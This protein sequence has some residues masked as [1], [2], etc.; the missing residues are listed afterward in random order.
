MVIPGTLIQSKLLPRFIRVFIAATLPV[1]NCIEFDVLHKTVPISFSD[2]RIATP[3]RK[4]L[5]KFTYNAAL[6]PPIIKYLPKIIHIL[7]I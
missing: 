1:I 7:L 6:K 2:S 5:L 3:Q 4:T